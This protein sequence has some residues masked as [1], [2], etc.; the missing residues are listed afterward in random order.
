VGTFQDAQIS[1]AIEFRAAQAPRDRSPARY[2][3]S[4]PVTARPTIIRW[5]SDVPS[6]M[7]KILA[8]RAFSAGQRPATAVVSARIQ[9]A[10]SEVNV[11]FGSARVRFRSWYERTPRRYLCPSVAATG[12]LLRG[13]P[14][15]G[16]FSR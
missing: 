3:I 11:G 14:I 5:I 10:P 12:N 9:H 2:R 4:S 13:G 16:T 8:A 15:R 1:H 6:K 7:V